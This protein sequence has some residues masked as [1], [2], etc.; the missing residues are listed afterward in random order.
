ML[1]FKID[2]VFPYVNNTDPKWIKEYKKYADDSIGASKNRFQDYGTLKYLLRGIAENMPWINNLY[3]LVASESQVP[4]WLNRKNVKV[5]LHKDFIPS[6]YLPT[7]NSSTIELF[8]H[9]IPGLQEHFIYGNDDTFVYKPLQPEDFFKFGLPILEISNFDSQKT[10]FDKLVKRSYSNARKLVNKEQGKPAVDVEMG[11]IKP[12][13]FQ[14]GILKST[15]KKMIKFIEESGNLDT[16][17][18]RF[19]DLSTNVNQYM[20]ADYQVLSHRYIRREEK[21]TLGK[22]ISCGAIRLENIEKIIMSNEYP[23]LCLNDSG[24]NED[25][26]SFIE[27]FFKRKFP[28]PCKYEE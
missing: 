20:Y 15:A 22:Y 17:A 9:R 24:L 25:Y 7:F 16:Y 1:D 11:F 3:I 5:I 8:L 27:A 14:M 23:L 12:A 2:Y 6:K 18:T 10:T 4:S 28:E 19:R 13:H 21:D 26:F